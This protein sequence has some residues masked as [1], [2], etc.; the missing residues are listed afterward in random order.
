MVS[1]LGV[2]AINADFGDQHAS[3][4][5]FTANIDTE[6]RKLFLFSINTKNPGE[7]TFLI[8]CIAGK[9]G[10]A[11]EIRIPVRPPPTSQAYAM[12]GDVPNE[13]V[14]VQSIHRPSETIPDFGGVQVR[15]VMKTV[16][17]IS[18]DI[19]NLSDAWNPIEE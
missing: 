8:S 7:A 12:D 5:G 9:Y 16:H 4:T 15:H 11:S 19:L 14:V 3:E 2:R 1:R 17:E 18:M 6:N 10:D 13:E